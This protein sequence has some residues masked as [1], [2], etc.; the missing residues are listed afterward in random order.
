MRQIGCWGQQFRTC[1]ASALHTCDS[2][3]VHG[4]R[5]AAELPAEA[6]LQREICAEQLERLDIGI[7]AVVS[8]QDKQSVFM[9][10]LAQQKDTL[11][12]CAV[13]RADGS[14]IWCKQSKLKLHLRSFLLCPFSS[15][16][17]LPTFQPNWSSHKTTKPQMSPR[18]YRQRRAR[19]SRLRKDAV[20]VSVIY[21][22]NIVL[23]ARCNIPNMILQRPHAFV[24]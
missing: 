14:T 13:T 20:Q 15:A 21:F 6:D 18:S 22:Y 8:R 1:S 4:E 10:L 19:N 2:E 7:C 9:C 23:W 16:P 11:I 3:Q 12:A 24:V 17:E 5:L